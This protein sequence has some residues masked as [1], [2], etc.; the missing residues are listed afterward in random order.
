MAPT[1]EQQEYAKLLN[2]YLQGTDTY[3]K[4]AS[5]LKDKTFDQT[6][7]CIRIYFNVTSNYAE[8]DDRSLI[9]FYEI[10]SATLD[11]DIEGY[12]ALRFETLAQIS[13]TSWRVRYKLLDTKFTKLRNR[14]AHLVIQKK[15]RLFPRVKDFLKEFNNYIAKPKDQKERYTNFILKLK[16]PDVYGCLKAYIEVSQRLPNNHHESLTTFFALSHQALNVGSHYFAAEYE[17]KINSEGRVWKQ[18][19]DALNDWQKNGKLLPLIKEKKQ[20]VSTKKL[21]RHIYEIE[22]VEKYK[23]PIVVNIAP[24]RAQPEDEKPTIKWTPSQLKFIDEFHKFMARGKGD[25]QAKDQFLDWVKKS[26]S[27]DIPRSKEVIRTYVH[28]YFQESKRYSEN[29]TRAVEIF[30]DILKIAVEK[31]DAY[32]ALKVDFSIKQE[33]SQWAKRYKLLL[34]DQQIGLKSEI[35]KKQKS[36]TIIDTL[37]IA[38]FD[39]NHRD[40]DL[41][42]LR[43][44]NLV[45]SEE[46]GRALSNILNGCSYAFVVHDR[47]ELREQHQKFGKEFEELSKL[48]QEEDDLIVLLAMVQRCRDH[49]GMRPQLRRQLRWYMIGVMYIKAV[50]QRALVY[51]GKNLTEEERVFLFDEDDTR[52][53]HFSDFV[54]RF[55]YLWKYRQGRPTFTQ[56]TKAYIQM[57]MTA[58]SYRMDLVPLQEAAI[59]HSFADVLL[60]KTL[61]DINIYLD[62]IENQIPIR[63][64]KTRR[65]FEVIDNVYIFWWHRVNPSRVYI[66]VD[67]LGEILFR[68]SLDRLK[69]I[70][71]YEIYSIIHKN[72]KHIL[73]LMPVVFQFLGYLPDLITGGLSGLVKSVVFDLALEKTASAL[74][75]DSNIAQLVVFGA[76]LL[77]HH[78]MSIGTKLDVP[79]R[80]I[81]ITS[82]ERGKSLWVA[83]TGAKNPHTDRPLNTSDDPVSSY[84]TSHRPGGQTSDDPGGGYTPPDR[85]GGQDPRGEWEVGGFRVR[86]EDDVAYDAPSAANDRYTDTKMTGTTGVHDNATNQSSVPDVEIPPATRQDLEDAEKRLEELQRKL[87]TAEK[88]MN[89][90]DERV[91]DV[92]YN[93]EQVRGKL[94]EPTIK[95]ELDDVEKAYTLASKEYTK[96]KIEHATAKSKV[97]RIRSELAARGELE[98]PRK[99][100]GNQWNLPDTPVTYHYGN[101]EAESWLPYAYV[102]TVGNERGR[103]TLERLLNQDPDGYLSIALLNSRGKL[104]T[105]REKGSDMSHWE[106]HPEIIEQAHV[107]TRGAGRDVYIVMTKARNQR[108]GNDLERTGDIF[109]DEAIV[110]QGIAIDRLSALDL[111]DKG[112]LPKSVVEKAQVIRFDI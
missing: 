107:L 6:E 96:Y 28:A 45:I 106:A 86:G 34:P 8:N 11:K 67:G 99:S 37:K 59:V 57:L 100:L 79:I 54:L 29:N 50:Q 62:K 73:V 24:E 42:S 103:R 4:L 16:H 74:G 12:F 85:P 89:Q 23:D 49:Q 83:D 84:T 47:V 65:I 63:P 18:R 76:G 75:V 43:S 94:H 55:D 90:T 30:Y 108:F 58:N 68:V 77:S 27:E 88:V 109:K 3:H 112:L 111:V 66:K 33:R 10:M 72:T 13:D 20:I 97:D 110:I 5:Y 36:A 22:T 93:L 69:E 78:A 98:V 61:G 53:M 15:A 44:F 52:D 1:L 70:D 26:T 95:K 92:Q 31:N 38:Y 102:G 80:D 39:G 40:P 46:K 21:S 48:L 51:N 17:S 81:N 19:F 87:D 60:N 2:E 14:L 25:E 64:G 32:Y 104:H 101:V 41:K 9:A 82:T 7:S 56:L 35:E 71:Y 91:G 105:A